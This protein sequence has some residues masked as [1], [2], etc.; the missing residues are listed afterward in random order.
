MNVQ[1]ESTVEERQICLAEKS[2]MQEIPPSVEDLRLRDAIECIDEKLGPKKKFNDR[3]DDEYK[4][5]GLYQRF[6]LSIDVLF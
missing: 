6:W 3:H 1:K 5:D 4:V 2:Q